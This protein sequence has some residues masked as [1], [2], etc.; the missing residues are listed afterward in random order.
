MR[1][2]Q[3]SGL[4]PSYLARLNQLAPE[5]LGFEE[6]RRI[7]LDDRFGA[8]HF[9]KPVLDGDP[10]AFFTNGDDEILQR[11]WARENGMRAKPPLEDILLAQIEHHR[12]EVFYNLDPV[13]YPSSF[14]RKL[15][16]MCQENALLAGGTVGKCRFDGLWRGAW[17]FSFD[18]GFLAPQRL[19][20]RIVFSCGRSFD[21]RVWTWRA[22]YRCAFRW[23]LF[24]TSFRARENS[25]TGRESRRNAAGGLLP[26]RVAADRLAESPLGRLLP[27]TKTSSPK[28]DCENR[29]A[30]DFWAAALRIDRKV[31]DRAERCHRYGRS[32]SGKYALF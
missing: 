3:N 2:F 21:G 12:T 22:T 26:R 17:K 14:V 1:L 4:Y 10:D 18:P 6:R 31:K 5:A 13:R 9:L 29:Q 11:H 19:P 25:R 20:S 28:S 32:G 16:G 8:L 15:P 24:P 27:L 23:R 7:F 30:S